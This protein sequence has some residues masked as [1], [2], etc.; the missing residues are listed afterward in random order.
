MRGASPLRI[1]HSATFCQIWYT[2]N[3]IPFA[4]SIFGG[5][6]RV[7]SG[8][9]CA[10]FSKSVPYLSFWSK[11]GQNRGGTS[12]FVVQVHFCVALLFFKFRKHVCKFFTRRLYFRWRRWS[13]TKHKVWTHGVCTAKK[14]VKIGTSIFFSKSRNAGHRFFSACQIWF[15]NISGVFKASLHFI[16]FIESMRNLACTFKCLWIK[17]VF[18]LPVCTSEMF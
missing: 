15:E 14:K 12:V 10:N 16:I 2:K 17:N 7:P 5:T 18:K 4:V 9:L 8:F 13:R 11:Y 6:F 1:L 3:Y